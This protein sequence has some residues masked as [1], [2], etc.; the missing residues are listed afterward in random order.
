MRWFQDMRLGRKMLTMAAAMLALYA[1]I[2]TI[3]VVQTNRLAGATHEVTHNWMP[4]VQ[5]LLT[6]ARLTAEHRILENRALLLA[7]D[8]P[9]RGTTYQQL[10]AVAARIASTQSSYERLISSPDE[11]RL[12]DGY[13]ASWVDYQRISVEV[14]GLNESGK[15]EQ[16]IAALLGP[17]LKSFVD[18]NGALDRVVTI[19]EQ[20]AAAEAKRAD[21]LGDSTQTMIAGL[22]LTALAVGLG[23]ALWISRLVTRPLVELIAIARSLADGDFTVTLPRP[24]KDETGQ[25]VAAMEAMRSGLARVIG[26]VRSSAAAVATA[27]GQ[28][29]SGT[30]DLSARTEQQAASIEQTAAAMD[31]LAG[32]VQSSAEVASRADARSGSAAEV[33]QRGGEAVSQVMHAMNGIADGSRRI[34]DIIAVIDGIAFQTNILALNA[35]VEA[36]RAGEQGR[37]FAVVAAEVRTLAQRSSDAAREIKQL[38]GASTT[39]VAAGNR[40]AAEAGRIAEDVVQAIREVRSLVADIAASAGQQAQ[41]VGQVNQAV[42]DIDA[43]TQQNAALVEQN[44]AAAGSLREQAATLARSVESFRVSS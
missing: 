36:A 40:A 18:L 19:N 41:G 31:E 35:A 12:Y 22:A 39:Q 27:S 25:L 38:I 23:L 44:S 17:S 34:T 8:A 42:A 37:G 32:T 5:T 4:S 29:A 43:S 13:R 33:A 7:G 21:A 9:Q 3:A 30:Q 11:R 16:S 15:A 20:G 24:S 6:L 10:E 2:S 1:A 14:R 28:I 26:D